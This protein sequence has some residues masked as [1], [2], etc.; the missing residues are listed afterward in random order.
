M[1]NN[2]LRCPAHQTIGDPMAPMPPMVFESRE[3]N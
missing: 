1:G 2:D 3:R